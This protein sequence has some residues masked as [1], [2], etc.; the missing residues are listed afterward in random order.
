MCGIIAR[1]PSSRRAGA[2]RPGASSSRPLRRRRRRRSSPAPA[3]RRSSTRPPPPSSAVDAALR[4]VPGVRGA[5]RPTAAGD[6]R[7]S[8]DRRRAPRR[9]LGRASRPRSTPTRDRSTAPSS[10]RSTPRWSARK[11]AVWA[12]AP[13]PAAHGPRRRRPRRRRA[14]GRPRSRR[15]RRSSRRCRRSTGSRCAAATRPASTCSCATTASTSPTRRSPASL[16]RRAT[17]PLFQLRCGARRRR[18]PRASSTRPRPRSASSA[19]TPRALRA[20]DPRRRAAAPARSAPT[21]PRPSCSATPAGRAS[22]SSPSPTPTRSTTRRSDGADGP[23]VAA[24]L[25]GDVDNYADLKA[26][27]GLRIAGRD[28]HRRQGH[29]GA[30]VAAHRPSGADLDRGVPRARSPRFEGS[31]AI[32]RQPPRRPRPAAAR[33]AGQRPGALRRPRRGRLRRRE[34]ALRRWSRRPPTYLRLDGETPGRPRQPGGE[35]RAR[36]SCSTARAAGDARRHRAGCAYDGTAAAGDRRRARTAP[37]SPPATSTAATSPH[38]LLKEISEAPGVV[39]QDAARQARRA[40]RRAS[41]VDARRPRRCP[42]TVARPRCA[43]GAIRRVLVIGQGTAAVAG[44]SARRRR[45]TSARRRP[46][47]GVEADPGHRAL[48]LRAAR[49]H[50]RHARRRDQP[51]RHHHRH[52]PHGRPRPRPR[53]AR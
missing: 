20:R 41:H 10:R 31:V 5:A 37:R 8:S 50:V 27:E 25:N 15:S 19:T 39:P 45:S 42:P 1:R 16:D 47:L 18:L 51:E 35:P 22:A 17:D 7:R 21:T 26:L 3:T 28:H 43:D 29:P 32:A 23:Y 44:Q 2:A 13:R 11:D 48:G 46:A 36:S 49:R 38:F 40:R 14:P 52:Q 6:A 53:R 33:A 24:A 12:V 34:R 9:P 4:G 30:R